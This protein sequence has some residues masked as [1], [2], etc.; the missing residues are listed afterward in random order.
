MAFMVDGQKTRN[1]FYKLRLKGDIE[2]RVGIIGHFMFK[3]DQCNGQAIK[4]LNYYKELQKHYKNEVLY[5]DTLNVKKSLIYNSFVLLKMCIVCRAII[6]MPTKALLYRGAI[7]LNCLKKIFK[8]KLIYVVVGGWLPEEVSCNFKLK[9]ELDKFEAILV[10]TKLMK[11]N[12]EKQGMKNIYYSPNFSTKVVPNNLKKNRSNIVPFKYCTFSRVTKSKGILDAI[13]AISLVNQRAGKRICSLDI[14]GPVDEEFKKEFFSVV[15][16][17]D[18]VSYCG[19]LNNKNT[20]GVLS[21]YYAMLFPTQYAGEGFPGAVVEAMMAGTPVIASDWKY[22]S[23]V[24]ID[25]KTGYIY[26]VGDIELLVRLIEKLNNDKNI[27]YA[28][29]ETSKE[30]SKKYSADQVM[31]VLY[32]FIEEPKI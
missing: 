16:S 22:N 24:I 32:Q 19:V 13:K 30:Y 2:M 1:Y 20:I 18:E 17:Y 15:E 6:F 9:K 25:G 21:E 11:T 14:Y 8:F 12:L 28:M 27:T 23:E 3:G 5:L 29:S 10:E 7:I 4:T 31:K 26:P